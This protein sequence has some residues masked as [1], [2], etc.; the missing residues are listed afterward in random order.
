MFDNPILRRELTSTLRAR[1]TFFLAALYL[2]GLAAVVWF[3]WPREGIYS[4]AAQSSC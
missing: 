2:V 3:L 4:L 1:L